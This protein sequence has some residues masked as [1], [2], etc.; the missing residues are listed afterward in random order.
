MFKIFFEIEFIIYSIRR[1]VVRWVVRCGVNDILIKRVGRWYVE[2][3]F[4]LY[5]CIYFLM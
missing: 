2:K 3:G 4:L 5:I 1:F